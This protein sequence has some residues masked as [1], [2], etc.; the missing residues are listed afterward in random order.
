[1]SSTTG[2]ICSGTYP[3]WS[4]WLES[5]VPHC[6]MLP[7]HPQP[8]VPEPVQVNMMSL[9]LQDYSLLLHAKHRL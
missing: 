7:V 9:N 8:L 1:M 6:G 5:C 3:T 4:A 2:S